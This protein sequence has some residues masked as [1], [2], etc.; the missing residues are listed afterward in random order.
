MKYSASKLNPIT[1]FIFSLLF[2]ASAVQAQNYPPFNPNFQAPPAPADT[3]DLYAP[4]SKQ[5]PVAEFG[6]P[7][8]FSPAPGSLKHYPQ[9]MDFPTPEEMAKMKPASQVTEETIKQRFAEQK[10]ILQKQLDKDRAAADE[11][12]KNFAEYQKLR[13]DQ[14]AQIMKRAEISRQA[15]MIQLEEAEKNALAKF[16]S[17]QKSEPAKE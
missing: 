4:N 2:P 6:N 15:V 7:P 5:P 9:L 11:Y 12:A 10:E 14:L 13:A 17:M 3:Y 8:A 16:K 1:L